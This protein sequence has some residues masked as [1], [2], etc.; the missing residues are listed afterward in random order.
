MRCTRMVSIGAVI[1]CRLALPRPA[2]GAVGQQPHTGAP[3]NQ[4]SAP[5]RGRRFG[6]RGFQSPASK[7]AFRPPSGASLAQ[8]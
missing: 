3:S 1:L 7:M 2:W 6:K 8:V 5:G 4:T